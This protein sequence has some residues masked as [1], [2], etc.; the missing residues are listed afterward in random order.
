MS[1]IL[2]TQ[3][4]EL[5]WRHWTALGVAGVAPL[6]KH[7]VD[8]EALIAFTP[9]IAVADPRLAQ[10]C[11]DWCMRVGPGNVSISRLRQITRL[12]PADSARGDVE[13]FDLPNLMINA[14]STKASRI[15]LSQKSQRPRLAHPSMI[16]LRSRHIFGVGA[17]ADAIAALTMRARNAEAVKISAILTV[18]YTKRTIAMVIEDLVAA[19]VL[20]QFVVNQTARYKLLRGAPLRTLLAPLPKKMPSWPERFALVAAVLATWRR[21]GTRAS[22]AIELAKVLNKLR[23]IA[24]AINEK[25]PI[26]DRPHNIL[27]EVARWSSELLDP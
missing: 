25:P 20:Q 10:E 14:A 24:A 8:V 26:M 6:P 13:V 1:E 5:A 12:M 11:L 18:G 21:F 3:A 7:A 23:P 17:R 16:Q 4:V 19:G 22:Y 2:Q 27:S 9:F 15:K